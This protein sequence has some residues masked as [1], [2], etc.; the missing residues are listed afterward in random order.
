[1]QSKSEPMSPECLRTHTNIRFLPAEGTGV[2]GSGDGKSVERAHVD[3]DQLVGSDADK[4]GERAIY[5][6]NI[7]LLVMN[8]DEIR[9]GIK[10]FQPVTVGLLHAGE[11]AR[12]LERDAGVSGNGA[13]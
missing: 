13:Q 4:I 8:D 11:Q 6:K 2:R 5:A 10:N 9:D 3:A 12:I 1:M 7:V